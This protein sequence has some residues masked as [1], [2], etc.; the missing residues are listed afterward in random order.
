MAEINKAYNLTH[1]V[2]YLI[3][4]CIFLQVELAIQTENSIK[5][6]SINLLRTGFFNIKLRLWEMGK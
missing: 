1:V 3:F 5:L 6:L 4:A 2:L